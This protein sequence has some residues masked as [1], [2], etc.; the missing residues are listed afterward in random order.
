MLVVD[1][2][3]G[4]VIMLRIL[5][6]AQLTLEIEPTV[7]A[8]CPKD[9]IYIYIINVP[10]ELGFEKEINIV[11]LARTSLLPSNC[12]RLLIMDA[13]LLITP[14]VSLVSLCCGA[15]WTAT[16]AMAKARHPLD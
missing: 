13:I 15:R 7:V 5:T 10:S 6:K 9:V 16:L 12:S 3:N 8:C 11:P 1:T 14:R 2:E 4:S